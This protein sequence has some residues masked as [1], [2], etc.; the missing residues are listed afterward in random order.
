MKPQQHNHGTTQ[1]HVGSI[2]FLARGV[3]A[4]AVSD[5]C[6]T[7][8]TLCAG[9]LLVL[10]LLIYCFFRIFVIMRPCFIQ[11][12]SFRAGDHLF[13]LQIPSSLSLYM[14]RGVY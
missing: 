9:V 8:G 11:H 14:R 4:T 7:S 13:L 6:V 3:P 10:V 1:E 12:V 2:L 5:V